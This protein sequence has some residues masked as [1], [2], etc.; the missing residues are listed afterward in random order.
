VILG[1]G[2]I[3][4][5][6]IYGLSIQSWFSFSTMM[7]QAN[8]VPTLSVPVTAL[9]DSSTNLFTY[10]NYD[11][12][13]VFCG[14]TKL[15]LCRNDHQNAYVAGDTIA[16]LTYDLSTLPNTNDT[17]RLT[18]F[19]NA[20]TVGGFQVNL[21][22][23]SDSVLMSAITSTESLTNSSLIVYPNPVKDVLHIDNRSEG[24][25]EILIYDCIGNLILHEKNLGSIVTVG[26]K[27]L[28]PGIYFLKCLTNEN[29]V[30]GRIIVEH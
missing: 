14:N 8:L 16:R 6:S 23:V 29:V 24:L 20:I 9:G 21:S 25:D 15:V 12:S 1:S 18:A 3:A 22:I 7:P 27:E 28:S 11:S 10:F 4:I 13:G 5:D 2:S 30:T 26:V 19:A 17:L